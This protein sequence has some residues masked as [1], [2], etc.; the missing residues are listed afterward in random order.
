[1][2]PKIRVVSAENAKRFTKVSDGLFL[3]NKTGYYYVRQS[4][5]RQRIPDLFETTKEKTLGKAKSKARAMVAAHLSRFMGGKQASS[6]RH[7]LSVREVI[8]EFLRTQTPQ[9]RVGTQEKHRMYFAELISEWGQ[10]SIDRMTLSAWQDWLRGFRLRKQR[11][12]YMDYAKNMNTILRYAYTHKYSTHLLVLP[13][14]DT[15]KKKAGR[16][17]T[18]EEIGRL[19]EAMG[20]ETRD[21]FS[22]C[23]ECFMRLREALKLTWDR[24]DIDSG[25]VT[26]TKDDVKTGSKTGRGR[27]FVLAPNTLERMRKRYADRGSS[28]YVFPSKQDPSKPVHDNKTAWKAAK[29]RAKITGRA[30][31]HDLRHTALTRALLVSRVEPI[32][33]SEYAGVSLKTIQQVYLHATAEKTASV[34]GSVSIPA[35]RGVGKA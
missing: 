3:N 27:S 33:V 2:H 30:R 34:A 18:D 22:L 14:P 17:Y 23:Y 12:T 35:L 15:N 9:R 5:K 6:S 4:F 13:N 29:R 28:P 10:W 32:L 1:V 21:Q 19:W 8:E 24:V 31:W 11:Q 20:E 26:L 25:V 7:G 16:V